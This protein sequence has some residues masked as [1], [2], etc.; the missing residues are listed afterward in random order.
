M[1][2]GTSKVRLSGRCLCGGV[3][4]KTPLPHHIDIC[5]CETC[6]RWNGGPFIGIDIREDIEFEASESLTWY[7]SSE[8]A[9]RGFCNIC[10]AS[11]FYRLKAQPN[12]WS[13]AGGAVDL[14]E[15]LSVAKEIF[16]DEKPDYYQFAGNHP[17]LTGEEAF[18]AFAAEDAEMSQ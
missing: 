2:D 11:L 7:K 18:A 1:S 4:F 16:V 10:G 12:F 15:G 3:A 5:H 6:R 8:W 17:R 14:P 9:Q 13:I